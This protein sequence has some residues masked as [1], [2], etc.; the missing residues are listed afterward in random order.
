M[1]HSKRPK[2]QQAFGDGIPNDTARGADDITNISFFLLFAAIGGA[3]SSL[4]QAFQS[5]AAHTLAIG[6]SNELDIMK[7]IKCYETLRT[8]YPSNSYF[9]RGIMMDIGGAILVV[10]AMAHAP[11]F[12]VQPVASCG[13]AVLALYSHYYMK[14]LHIVVLINNYSFVIHLFF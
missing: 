4:G 1:L 7:P 10:Y 13:L 11:V 8:K 9:M 14:V 12:M 5:R 2:I 3:S 6:S